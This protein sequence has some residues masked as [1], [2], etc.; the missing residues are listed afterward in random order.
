MYKVHVDYP[1]SYEDFTNINRIERSKAYIYLYGK[2]ND[3]I[4]SLYNANYVK[5]EE[6]KDDNERRSNNL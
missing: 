1:R 2:D 5:I 6:E 3:I 4:V